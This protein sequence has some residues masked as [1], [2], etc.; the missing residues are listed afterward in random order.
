MTTID[1][2]Y[3][4]LADVWNMTGTPAVATV[5]LGVM[6]ALA[7]LLIQLEVLVE[8]MSIGIVIIMTMTYKV[9]Y[10]TIC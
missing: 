4:W 7:A 5:V 3:R 1:F 6:A 2:L 8:M 10:G 9:T